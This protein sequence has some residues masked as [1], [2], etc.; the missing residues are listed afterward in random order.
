MSI[1]LIKFAFVAGE[2]ADNFYGRSDLEKYDLALAL[3]ENWFID[4]R[5]GISTRAGSIFCDYVKNDTL[6][7]K[8]VPFSFSS[9]DIANTNVILFGDEY[10]RFIQ[11]GAYVLEADKNITA[12]TQANPGVVTSAAHGFVV[13]DWVRITGVGGMTGVNS[14]GTFQVGTTA[15]NTFQL[16]D[17]RTGANFSTV[18]FPAYTAGGTVARI[19]TLVSPYQ[20]EDLDRLRHHQIRDTL[21]LTHSLYATRNLTRSGPTSWALVEEDFDISIDRPEDVTTTEHSADTFGVAYAV[22]AVLDG[23]ESIQSETRFETNCQDDASVNFGV[24]VTWD[25]VPGVD[26]Y[27]VYKSTIARQQETLN[28]G[29][30][31]GFIG[32]APGAV[33]IDAGITPDFTHTPPRHRNPFAN[34]AVLRVS[35]IN[36][37]S[38]YGRDDTLAINGAPGVDAIIAPVVRVQPGGSSGPLE[39][40]IVL[41]GGRNYVN[42]V[43][44]DSGA[45]SGATF[46]IELSPASGNYP[47][48]GCLFQQ[49]QI[50]A[51]QDNNPLTL[52]GSRPG[53]L[54]NFGVS[55]IQQAD[56]AYEFEIDSE[57]VSALRHLIPTR[58]GLLVL[59]GSGIWQLT[60]TNGSAV[61]ATSI[62]ADPQVAKGASYLPPIKIDSEVLYTEAKGG[63][64][65]LLSYND[66][67]KVYGT[68]DMSLLAN[69]LITRTK[70]ITRWAFAFEPYRTAWAVRSDGALLSFAFLKDQNVFAWARHRTRGLFKD[71]LSIQEDRAETIYFMVQRFVNGRWSK[72]IEKFDDRVFDHVEDSFCVDCGL[73][74]E[75]EA[76]AATLQLSASTGTAT[77][78]ASAAVFAAGDVG[79]VIR[80]GG[81]KMNVTVFTNPTTVTVEII[82]PVTELVFETTIPLLTQSGEWTMDAPISLVSGL[83]H[84]EGETV[85]VVAD[86]NVLSDKVVTSGG[87]TLDAPAT[88]VYV[89][90]KYKCTAQNL[91]L[92]VTSE[93]VENK[94]KRVTALAVR[95]KDTRGLKSGA[96]LS[97]LYP[98][99]EKTNQLYGEPI[100]LFSGMR[101]LLLEPHWNEEGQTFLV[102]DEPLPATVLGYVTETEIGDDPS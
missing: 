33:F 99:K 14:Q 49:R 9:D 28:Q 22:T 100:P 39:G 21:R 75:G 76:P 50:Y 87:I 45:G 15:A 80:S 73:F 84:I 27:K 25:P 42:P 18:G 83:N 59:N 46:D 102:Q 89:G 74:L 101:H 66:I 6:D 7:T 38:N 71:V 92:N 96:S 5:G 52:H 1:D 8:F 16:K 51:A 90:L 95:I 68:A 32:R 41:N 36:Q 60:G 12:I 70:Q 82:R 26:Y 31:L 79:K 97:K 44:T 78:T 63:A 13:G 55:D 24:S 77:A 88:R 30:L 34:S 43:I 40:V 20:A 3:A 23:E 47:A 35:L 56:D 61:T 69:H 85:K 58:G 19:Y 29:V 67:A 17:P 94:R 11:D 2:I 4:Y 72:F 91:P 62:V 65:Q 48:I 86:G 53:Q 57:D 54:S 10:I 81:G 93:V 37:G 64:V 98:M